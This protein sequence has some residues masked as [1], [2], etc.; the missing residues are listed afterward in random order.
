MSSYS[1][2]SELSATYK[3]GILLSVYARARARA[4]VCE[5]VVILASTPVIHRK[6]V[7]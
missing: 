1:P 7:I 3:R 4:C 6:L 2:N 5:L